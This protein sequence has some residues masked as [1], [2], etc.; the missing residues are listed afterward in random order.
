MLTHTHTHAHTHALCISNCPAA[1]A[2]LE[3]SPGGDAV[4]A[5]AT[6]QYVNMSDPVL[7]DFLTTFFPSSPT[8]SCGTLFVQRGIGF[9]QTSSDRFRPA[10]ARPDQNKHTCM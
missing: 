1:E 6:Y 9:G 8:E 7:T 3:H 5:Y 2:E 4:Q 10:H